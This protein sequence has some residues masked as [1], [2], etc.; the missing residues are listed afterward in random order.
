[1]VARCQLWA[2]L[3][4]HRPRDGRGLPPSMTELTKERIQLI[5]FAREPNSPSSSLLTSCGASQVY[6]SAARRVLAVSSARCV[7]ANA[8]CGRPPAPS[9]NPGR[10]AC[11]ASQWVEIAGAA[12]AAPRKYSASSALPS[13][14]AARAAAPSAKAYHVI[15]HGSLN[16]PARDGRTSAQAAAPGRTMAVLR[17]A[18]EGLA[19]EAPDASLHDGVRHRYDA[20]LPTMQSVS[21]PTD[22]T[23]EGGSA[24]RRYAASFG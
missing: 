16:I 9:A 6:Q 7:E 21:L 23:L 24:R 19:V 12:M 22:A 2:W 1:M 10:P 14:S 11:S 17:I 15:G 13:V 3:F 20:R 4:D 8:S 5:I 18:L